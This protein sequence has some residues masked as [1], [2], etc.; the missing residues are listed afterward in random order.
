MFAVSGILISS[1]VG[2]LS[3]LILSPTEHV[4][5]KLAAISSSV[6]ITSSEA[7]TDESSDI[8]VTV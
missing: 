4:A 1:L 5:M 7:F 3:I 2:V 8:G 6:S